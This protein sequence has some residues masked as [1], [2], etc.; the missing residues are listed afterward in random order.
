MVTGDRAEQIYKYIGEYT[1]TDNDT[2]IV[3]QFNRFILSNAPKRD[4]AAIILFLLLIGSL[5]VLVCDDIAVRSERA[6]NRSQIIQYQLS[7]SA[8]DAIGQEIVY[9]TKYGAKYH[10]PGCPHIKDREVKELTVDDAISSGYGPC[11]TC[12]PPVV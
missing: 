5:I 7:Q 10:L 8:A 9:V 2:Q 1:G 3:K 4:F 12:D 11:K 6:D